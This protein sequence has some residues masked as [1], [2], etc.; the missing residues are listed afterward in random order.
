[1]INKK[2]IIL[3]LTVTV[4]TSFFIS[5]CGKHANDIVQIETSTYSSEEILDT[6][7]TPFQNAA[8][9]F[10][11][12]SKGDNQLTTQCEQ[13]SSY[14][15]KIVYNDVLSK[16]KANGLVDIKSEY[17]TNAAKMLELDIVKNNESANKY[18]NELLAALND[19]YKSVYQTTCTSTND[20]KTDLQAKRDLVITAKTNFISSFDSS[21]QSVLNDLWNIYSAI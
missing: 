10:S 14:G 5:G 6:I 19:Y 12:C 21:V 7:T 15:F 2:N 1:M 17:V 16:I 8:A 11:I 13:N 9:Y 3:L 18:Y 4:A 20:Y